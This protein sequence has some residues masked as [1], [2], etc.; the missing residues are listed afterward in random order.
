MEMDGAHLEASVLSSANPLL[1]L[2]LVLTAYEKDLVLTHS[3]EGSSSLALPNRPR[4][5]PAPP[6]RF[7]ECE[8]GGVKESGAGSGM[9][10]PR[11][12]L[13]ISCPLFAVHVCEPWLQAP[14][15]AAA[16]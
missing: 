5:V 2:N 10:S 15:R 4:T 13:M 9:P 7:Y 11:E 12:G 16:L 3:W 1:A 6:P 8:G 14:V